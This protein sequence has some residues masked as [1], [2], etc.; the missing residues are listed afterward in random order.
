VAIRLDHHLEWAGINFLR[1]IGRMN[2]GLARIQ[3]ENSCHSVVT[4]IRAYPFLISEIRGKKLLILG[5][6]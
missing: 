3:R 5:A 6:G 1:R 4:L 2:S